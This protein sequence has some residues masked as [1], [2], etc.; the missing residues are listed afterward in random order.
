MS[1]ILLFIA[2]ICCNIAL[3]SSSQAA[4][5]QKVTLEDIFVDSYRIGSELSEKDEEKKKLVSKAVERVST[6]FDVNGYKWFLD[7]LMNRKTKERFTQALVH[8]MFNKPHCDRGTWTDSVNGS[9]SQIPFPGGPYRSSGYDLSKWMA[10]LFKTVRTPASANQPGIA[11]M[12]MQSF[13][14]V[15]G[16]IQAAIAIVVDVVP[17]SILGT[18]LPC[19]P[20]L[21]GRNCIGSVLYPISATDF[22]VADIIDST[23]NGIISAFPAK[24]AAKV[25]RTSD[26]QYKICA[27][28]YLGMYCAS[29]FP[30]CATGAAQVTQTFPICFVQCL[31]TLVACPGFWIDDII[32]ACGGDVSVPPFCSF[33]LFVNH[34]RI[35]PQYTTYEASKL[36]PEACPKYDSKLDMP[37]DLYKGEVPH[38]AID[39]EAKEHVSIAKNLEKE[40]GE[41]MGASQLK[42]CDCDAIKTICQLHVPYPIHILPTATVSETHY[43][44]PEYISE[45]EKRCCIECKPIWEALYSV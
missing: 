40:L 36:Y 17:P 38:S 20:M 41:S 21:T 13:D 12:A 23:M 37:L 45:D 22:V 29:L 9:I 43:Q 42:P 2:I 10:N 26:V 25:G 19:L 35:P 16:I 5:A 8:P 24:Y 11:N 39:D 18:P 4:S 1:H 31:A 7:N 32:G 34:P 33:S 14:Q 3:L 15:K 27:T 28:A 44:T 6:S 30:M